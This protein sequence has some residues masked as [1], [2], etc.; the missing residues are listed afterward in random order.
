MRIMTKALARKW[1]KALRSGKYKQGRNRL[2]YG[3]QNGT[4]YCCLGV[5]EEAC[6]VPR[7]DGL[8]LRP[9]V[10]PSML[11][12]DLME[13]NDV[14]G[15]DFKHIAKHIEDHVIPRLPDKQE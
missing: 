12:S 5:A 10:L 15:A 14:E 4:F 3:N 2:K 6:G 9:G 7:N 13:M 11:Q 1:V 8:E